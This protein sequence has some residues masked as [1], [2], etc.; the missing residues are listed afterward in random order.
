MPPS[1]RPR[2]PLVGGIVGTVVAVAMLACALMFRAI[3]KQPE[4]DMAGDTRADVGWR[5]IA[6]VTFDD[7]RAD[8]IH[9]KLGEPGLQ[10][11]IED[12]AGRVAGNV[13]RGKWSP[14]GFDLRVFGDGGR[15]TEVSGDFKIADRGPSLVVLQAS[16]AQGNNMCMF[17][18]RHWGSRGSYVIQTRWLKHSARFIKGKKLARRAFGS[19]NDVFHTMRMVLD[20]E[21]SEIFYYVDDVLLGI[22]RVEGRMGPVTIAN[23]E[24]QAPKK[25]VD[26][27]TLYDNLRVRTSASLPWPKPVAGNTQPPVLDDIEA[28]PPLVVELDLHDGR[29][30]SGVPA[31][32][33]I[34]LRTSFGPIGL[35]VD[36]IRKITFTAGGTAKVELR[37]G[38][39]VNGAIETASIALTDDDGTKTVTPLPRIGL[40]NV[41]CIDPF[42]ESLQRGLLVHYSFN[43]GGDKVT[44]E[45]GNGNHGTFKGN[46]RLVPGIRGSAMLFNG[47]T[48]HVVMPM[49][50]ALQRMHTGDYTIAAW[51]RAYSIPDTST[52]AYAVVMKPGCNFGILYGFDSM[53]RLD[54][55]MK[56]DPKLDDEDP[57][58]RDGIKL[59]R[60]EAGPYSAQEWH[61][62][63]GIARAAHKRLLLYVD[64]KR[65]ADAV[66]DH[67]W[68]VLDYSRCEWCVAVAQ[69]T[70]DTW[71]W[72]AHGAIDEVCIYDR[73][74]SSD[75][76]TDLYNFSGGN[77]LG[78]PAP[79]LAPLKNASINELAR[80]MSHRR[81]R[82]SSRMRMPT[83]GSTPGRHSRRSAGSRVSAALSFLL[84]IRNIPP[85]LRHGWIS[86][87]EERSC[88]T[89]PTG[90]SSTMH[91]LLRP[92]SRTGTRRNRPTALPSASRAAA[93]GPW[94]FTSAY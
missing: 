12:G 70:G 86:K 94:S 78:S 31:A 71:R 6:E 69:P 83:S 38:D 88:P 87:R 54:Q 26:L 37:N 62:I 8:N 34:T 42:P 25:G 92:L 23:M 10:W 41:R 55:Y 56:I 19:E 58:H 2:H 1:T 50:E 45:S 63:V 17:F 18:E 72:S 20:R 53:I 90:S 43:R 75:E 32:T 22:T 7:N 57:K 81:S 27:D 89:A 64:G 68:I 59:L 47:R 29:R 67:D 85:T 33:S 15:L 9:L 24:T 61:H 40:L 30:I 49:S 66:W 14:S 28:E 3:V 4:S 65:V 82:S 35:A 16:T 79:P 91:L 51:F 74:L 36:K 76:V 11:S 84:D 60:A 46:P 80:A 21:T 93:I 73:S 52:D 48:D 39:T 5:T 44:D 77:N 13:E